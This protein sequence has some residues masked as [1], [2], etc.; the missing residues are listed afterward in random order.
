MSEGTKFLTKNAPKFS[1]N[2]LS[3]CFVGPKESCKFPRQISTKKKSSTSF[4]RS[5]GR[6]VAN[7]HHRPEIVAMPD[8]FSNKETLQFKG[9]N[10]HRYHDFDLIPRLPSENHALLKEGET[11]IKIKFALFLGGGGG[12]GWGRE[13]D[14]PKMLFVLGST[15]TIKM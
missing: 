3:L 15:M 9:A 14:H 4:C 5:A 6:T 2:L 12:V 11:T 7:L 13:E 10:Y 1:P 8:T